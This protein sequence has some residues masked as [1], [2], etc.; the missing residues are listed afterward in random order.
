VKRPDA[1]KLV[2]DITDEKI[3]ATINGLLVELG[4]RDGAADAIVASY[5]QRI[6]GL[7][8]A[9]AIATDFVTKNFEE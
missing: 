9:H 8:G 4:H 6:A 7:F 2:D 1:Q 5:N 3:K